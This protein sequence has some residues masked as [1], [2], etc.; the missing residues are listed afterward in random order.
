MKNL[1]AAT[2]TALILSTSL[3]HAQRPN[4]TAMTCSQAVNLVNTH[5]AIVLSTGRFTY[6]RYVGRHGFCMPGQY[7]KRAFVPTLD[8]QRCRIGYICVNDRFH[9]GGSMR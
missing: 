8:T 9:L 1:I 5:G 3:A 2:T 6:D 7:M 4:T